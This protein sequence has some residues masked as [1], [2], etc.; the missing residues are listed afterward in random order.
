[1]KTDFKCH[2]KPVEIPTFSFLE[3]LQ[4]PGIYIGSRHLAMGERVYIVVQSRHPDEV[5][6]V[7]PG[8][9]IFSIANRGWDSPDTRFYKANVSLRFVFDD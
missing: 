6:G 7:T 2:S 9:R 5:F 4:N 3:I 8:G 1:M